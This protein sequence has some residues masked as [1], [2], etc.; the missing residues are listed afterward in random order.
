[1][2]VE[3]TNKSMPLWA[4]AI[5]GLFSLAFILWLGKQIS[6]SLAQHPFSFGSILAYGAFLMVVV[7]NVYLLVNKVREWV[8]Y[9]SQLTPVLIVDY[10]TEFTENMDYHLR[11]L[12]I[13]GIEITFALLVVGYALARKLK[14]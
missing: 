9:L 12:Q 8:L 3:E 14:T 13:I 10:A 11:T 5:I 7:V 1:V 4:L 6:N 2:V